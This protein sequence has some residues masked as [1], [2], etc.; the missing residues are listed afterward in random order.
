MRGLACMR[1]QGSSWPSPPST[2]ISGAEALG[3]G[4]RAVEEHDPDVAIKMYVESL[5][6]YE[7]D[8]KQALGNDAYRATV[9]CMVRGE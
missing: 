7:M 1:S 5:D 9:G 8:D 4:A 6:L 2:L 3:R